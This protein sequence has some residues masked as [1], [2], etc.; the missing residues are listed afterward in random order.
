MS[1][2]TFVDWRTRTRRFTDL[3][4]Y[5]NDGYVLT[6]QDEPAQLTAATVTPPLFSVLGVPPLFGR[7]FT[8]EEGEGR[9][10]RVVLLSHGFWQRRLGGDP[11]VLGTALILDAEPYTV[12]GVMPASFRFPP[13]QDVDL[14]TPLAIPHQLIPVRGMRVYNVVGRLALGADASL[15]RAELVALAEEIAAEYPQSNRGWT[16]AVTPALD[17]VLGDT[18]TLLLL[19]SGAAAFVL[20]IG[21]VNVANLLLARATRQRGEYAM[22]ATLGAKPVHLRTAEQK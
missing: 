4:A 9:G 15:A 14:W 1:A 22:R 3:A 21:C 19:M 6:G 17:Q 2:G 5:Q 12:V 10:A 7:T 18:Q 11:E 8:D 13:D 16:A 20:L